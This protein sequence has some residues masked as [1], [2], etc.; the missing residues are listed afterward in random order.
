[1]LIL[2][3]QPTGAPLL[4]GDPLDEGEPTGWPVP[5]SDLIYLCLLPKSCALRQ[6][7]TFLVLCVDLAFLSSSRFP[8]LVLSPEQSQAF[9]MARFRWLLYN[10][11]S[12]PPF[13]AF[14]FLFC[15]GHLALRAST[16]SGP[17][18]QR[19][20]EP[21]PQPVAYSTSVHRKSSV[22]DGHYG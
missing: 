17:V 15:A 5:L 16:L 19:G 7:D 6:W 12:G 3:S 22:S 9:V 18:L 8:V 4:P 13:K 10:G 2:S 21:S 1:M 11:V 20:C 14:C